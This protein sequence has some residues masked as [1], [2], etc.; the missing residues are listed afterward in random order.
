MD[1]L[2]FS[3]W[4]SATMPQ[5]IE[6]LLAATMWRASTTTI[7]GWQPLLHALRAHAEELLPLRDVAAGKWSASC[8]LGATSIVQRFDDI[9]H[10]KLIATGKGSIFNILTR[11]TGST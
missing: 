8:W 10:N 1:I 7:P 2:S 3:L 9:L 5:G 6:T 11:S 4:A